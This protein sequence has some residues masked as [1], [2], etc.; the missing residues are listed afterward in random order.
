MCL[1]RCRPESKGVVAADTCRKLQ[2]QDK[3]GTSASPCLPLSLVWDICSIYSLLKTCQH[4]PSLLF[5]CAPLWEHRRAKSCSLCEVVYSHISDKMGWP[6]FSSISLTVP[7]KAQGSLWFDS[8]E[9]LGPIR[10]CLW[11][12]HWSRNKE[13]PCSKNLPKVFYT[14]RV[15]R[16]YSQ[17]M[18]PIVW[19][20]D[21][22][23]WNEWESIIWY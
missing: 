1:W 3:H 21:R 15:M 2:D 5:I 23:L 22:F 6:L 8:Y 12:S 4:H 11:G 7:L 17:K 18:A 10:V 16:R 9:R 13:V 19:Y 14:H 20:D